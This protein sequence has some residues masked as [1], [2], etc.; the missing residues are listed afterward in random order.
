MITLPSNLAIG[1]YLF[2]I[3]YPRFAIKT[4]YA[5]RNKQQ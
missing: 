1:Y 2:E 5:K 4:I 3:P